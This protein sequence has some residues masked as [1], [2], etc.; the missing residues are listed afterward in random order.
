MILAYQHF[1]YQIPKEYLNQ[2]RELSVLKMKESETR[3]QNILE[4]DLK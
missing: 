2:F 4:A 1:S 3:L